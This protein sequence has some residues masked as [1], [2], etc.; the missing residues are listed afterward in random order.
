M[1]EHY[2]HAVQSARR[3]SE[4]LEHGSAAHRKQSRDRQARGSRQ[5]GFKSGAAGGCSQP[6]Q[7]VARSSLLTAATAARTAATAARTAAARGALARTRV[8]GRPVHTMHW[9]G[10]KVWGAQAA[11]GWPFEIKQAAA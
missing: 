3:K 1:L 8:A 6:P 11:R 7:A 5:T 9:I 2:I 4:R 10:Q